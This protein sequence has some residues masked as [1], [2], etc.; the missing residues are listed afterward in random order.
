M[1]LWLARV[2]Y[3]GHFISGRGVETDPSKIEAIIK[4]PAPGDQKELRN[5]L[6]LTGYY[7]R[8]IQGYASICRP[9]TDLLKTDNFCWN[10]EANDS[11]ATLKKAMASTPVLALPNFNLPFEIEPDASNAS[12]GA[13]LQQNSHPIA[14]ISKKLGPRWQG[15]SEYEKE[16]LAIVFAI[17]KWG[18]YLLGRPFIIKTDKKA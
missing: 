13:V 10:G 15:L 6:G 4:W 9:L 18:Q 2:E 7:R 8:F 14:F 16:L 12:I 11:F 1:L 3:F 5:F 17:Q